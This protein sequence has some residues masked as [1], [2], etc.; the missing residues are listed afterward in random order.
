VHELSAALA[1][2]TRADL[3]RWGD[4]DN[5]RRPAWYAFTGLVY[6]G[7][8]PRTLDAAA[9]RRA[10]RRL[11]IL[12]GLYGLLGPMDLVEAYRLEMGVR[13]RP[14]G[15]VDLVDFWR[16]RLTAALD[17]ELGRGETVLSVASQ[18]YLRAL[19][20]TALGGPV[21]TPVFKERRTD[22]SLNTVPVH[23]KTARG[24]LLRHALLTGARRPGDLLGFDAHG[25]G[26]TGEP[27]EQGRWLFTRPARD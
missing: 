9:R 22:G 8:D 24:A 11:R 4:P 25:W 12:S 13:W 21:V 27:P 5:P 23:A 15:A 6:K 26:A 20:L 1:D 10:R 19:D 16:P 17:A 3:A 7:L 14:P 2:R 18:E